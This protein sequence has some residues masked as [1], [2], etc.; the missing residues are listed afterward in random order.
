MVDIFN[1]VKFCVARYFLVELHLDDV[2]EVL[3]AVGSKCL[4]DKYHR[5]IHW[6]NYDECLINS[7]D[8]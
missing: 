6:K 1:Y 5:K 7:G 4:V 8:I 2:L 3:L